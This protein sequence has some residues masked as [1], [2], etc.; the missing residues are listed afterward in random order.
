LN[1]AKRRDF[2]FFFFFLLL[3]SLSLSLPPLN[4]RANPF[5]MVRSKMRVLL[6]VL[7]LLAATRKWRNFVLSF[8]S[9]SV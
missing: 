2:F 1:D 6:L 5:P 9:L 3:F 7:V 4:E 8:L